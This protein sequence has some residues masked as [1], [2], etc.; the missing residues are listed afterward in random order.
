[1]ISDDPSRPDPEALLRLATEHHVAGRLEL[2]G[3][4][5]AQV[6]ELCP[7]HGQARHRLGVLALQLGQPEAALERFG[8]AVARDPAAWRSHCGLG[9][10]LAALGRVQAALEAFR[11]A[12]ELNPELPGSLA[13]RRR[14]LPDPGPGARRP[15][16]P[17]SRRRP[18]ART[19]P[20]PSTTWASPCRT[21][22]RRQRP[23]PPSAGPWN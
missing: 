5:Y 23:W 11:R 13:G 21:P 16:P 3:A 17:S 22:G 1:M 20:T 8:R 9:Q 4:G 14:G 6:L 15:W 7:E 19:G 12:A 10:A 18:C 2:A